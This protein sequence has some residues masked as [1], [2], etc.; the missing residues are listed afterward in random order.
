L[1]AILDASVVV[2]AVVPGREYHAEVRRW[3][4][5]IA[6]ALPPHIMPFESRHRDPPPR[7][8][9]ADSP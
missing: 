3:L 1:K 5:G 7:I 9:G 6:E 4:R 2:K 8:H